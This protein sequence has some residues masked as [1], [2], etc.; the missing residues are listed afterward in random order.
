MTIL[1][2]TNQDLLG[3]IKTVQDH[4]NETSCESVRCKCPVRLR[5]THGRLMK[6]TDRHIMRAKGTPIGKSECPI[7]GKPM[8]IG[9]KT[10]AIS[11]RLVELRSLGDG[12]QVSGL[13]NKIIRQW[14]YLSRNF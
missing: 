11:K 5:Q 12:L 14:N 7:V 1:R 8:K 13:E 2:Q 4:E 3:Q 9:T 10:H 6:G